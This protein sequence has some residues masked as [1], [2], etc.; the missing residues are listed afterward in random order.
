MF[1]K[2]KYIL[3]TASLVHDGSPDMF[4]MVESDYHVVPVLVVVSGHD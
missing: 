3:L 4:S 2:L 1:R